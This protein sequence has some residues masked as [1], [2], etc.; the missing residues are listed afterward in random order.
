MAGFESRYIQYQPSFIDTHCWVKEDPTA[1]TPTD[2]V[3]RADEPWTIHLEWKVDGIL[4][5]VVT[6]TWHVNVY[7][8]SM[9]PGPEFQ[10]PLPIVE[11]RFNVEP[12]TTN[13]AFNHRVDPGTVPV[14]IGH[15]RPYMLVATVVF[16]QP[17]GQPGPM[18]GFYEQPMLQFY[19]AAA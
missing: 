2:T 19:S 7:L 6:G 9:G 17:N 5:P 11:H 12:G 16:H 4:V 1:T 13:Y 18:A 15:S 10:L 14:E 8:E 3:I